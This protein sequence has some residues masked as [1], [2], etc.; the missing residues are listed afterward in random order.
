MKAI[1]RVIQVFAAPHPFA[2]DDEPVQ[3]RNLLA[4]NPHRQAQLAKAAVR[5]GG[6]KLMNGDD[7]PGHS[8][9]V[10][11]RSQ[12]SL[13]PQS[14]VRIL[15]VGRRFDSCTAYHRSVFWSLMLKLVKRS[16]L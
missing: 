11:N 1:V 2:R 16:D 5:T 6:L 4:R 12:I 10:S 9:V 14:V 8:H 13:S 3:L 15:S 7:R